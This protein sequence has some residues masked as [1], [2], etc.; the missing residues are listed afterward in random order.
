[1][2]IIVGYNGVD[3]QN[4]TTTTASVAVLACSA[5]VL[6]WIRGVISSKTQL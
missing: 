1:M 3:R 5:Y 6:G 4:S 2:I